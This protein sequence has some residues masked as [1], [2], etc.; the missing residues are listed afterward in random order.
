MVPHGAFEMNL[1]P[2]YG[3]Q[4]E[5]GGGGA[6]SPTDI[7]ASIA[8]MTR[9]LTK[10]APTKSHWRFVDG[11]DSIITPLAEAMATM[12]T[13]LA[14]NIRA[15]GDE[16]DP[17]DGY[18]LVLI[19]SENDS[20]TV[21]GNDLHVMGVVG[22]KWANSLRFQVGDIRRPNDFRLITYPIYKAAL[23]VLATAWACPW[24][25]AYAFDTS[26]RASRR[27]TAFDFAWIGYLSASLAEGLPASTEILTESTPGGGVILSAVEDVIDLGNLDHLRRS[28]VLTS[29]MSQRVGTDGLRS[30]SAS[31][32]PAR[33]GPY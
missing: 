1:F 24:A 30:G 8:E 5:W 29:I 12:P 19:G 16:T 11:E 6:S 14:R 4:S 20:D 17:D 9:G 28:G 23:E 7:G 13:F 25:V 2:T 18:L 3:I 15:D 22:S 32:L 26:S 27:T 21:A 33:S 31:L 10:L